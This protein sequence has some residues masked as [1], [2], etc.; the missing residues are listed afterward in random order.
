MATATVPKSKIV[1]GSFL[2]EERTTA[3]VFTPEDFTEEHRQIAQT[4]E[5]FARNEIVPMIERIEHKEFQVTRDLL[6]KAAELGLATVDI[7]EEYGGAD[8]DK[9]SSC[10]IADRIAVCGSFSVSFG[11]HVG[12]G[13]LPI[14]YFGTSEQ[15]KKYLPKLASGEWVAA[16]ALSENTSAS[17]AMNARTKAVLSADKKEWVLNGEKMWITNANFADVYIVFAKVDG[18]KFSAFIVEKT[19]PGFSVGAE[20]KKLGIRGSS[21]APLILNDCKVPAENLLGEI[22]KG[23]I[24]AFN[25]LNI[26]RFKLG[27]GVVGGARNALTNAISYAKERK[28]WGKSIADFGLIKEKLA[29]IAIGVYV[30]E[31]L[32]YRTVGMIETALAEIDKKAADASTQI[33]KGIEEYAVECSILKVWGSEMI[34]R[35][36]DE[37]VQI[38]GGYGFVEEYPAERSFRDARVNRIFEGT[39]EINRLIITGWLMKRAMGGQLAL[40]PAIK[41]LMDEVLAGPSMGEPLEGVLAA[42]RTIVANAKKTGLMVSGA[43]VQKYMMKLEDEQEVMG[44]MANM[45]IEV[46]SMESAVLRTMKLIEKNGEA[47]SQNAINMT[48]AYISGS[49]DKVE[50]EAKRVLAACAEG[51]MLRTQMAVLRRMFK[52]EPINSVE[53][54]K[55]IAARVIEAGKYVV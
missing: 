30:G 48:R 34:D 31:A 51:D 8:M 33:R 36:V 3:E 52:Y 17:D 1:G 11:G 54:R 40:M 47:A 24:I 4:T 6:K 13:T 19:F 55:A 18:E 26:G 35:V 32:A 25:T 38:Y 28:A 49:I 9:I 21:T 15:K 37:V 7:P 53:A 10:I 5:E 23:H 44:A 2:I 20:E 14:V 39:N 50:S 16:Y 43:A 12:I 42:E 46:F 29:N 41:K 45:I 22:G 27:A